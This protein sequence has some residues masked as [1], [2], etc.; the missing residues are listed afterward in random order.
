MSW[1]FSNASYSS[2][3]D[4]GS[5]DC[6]HVSDLSS[7]LFTKQNI[8]SFEDWNNLLLVFIVYLF[9]DEMMWLHVLWLLRFEACRYSCTHRLWMTNTA[10]SL[11][12]I[13]LVLVSIA[14]RDLT[15]HWGVW[16]IHNLMLHWGILYVFKTIV[17]ED[18]LLFIL[19]KTNSLLLEHEWLIELLI[20]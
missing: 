13:W 12:G 16:S 8:T 19:I 10:L 14:E 1:W 5:S 17:F 18:L 2:S 9:D 3:L 4:S 7:H 11:M 20:Q 6:I 15:E